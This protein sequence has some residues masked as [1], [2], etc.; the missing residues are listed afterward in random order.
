MKQSMRGTVLV[1]ASLLVLPLGCEKDEDTDTVAKGVRGEACLSHEDCGSHLVCGEDFTCADGDF[2]LEPTGKI[3]VGIQC[4]V[5]KDCCPEPSE[6]CDQYEDLCDDGDGDSTSCDMY[7]MYCE[8]DE[9]S[10]RC[11]TDLCVSLCEEDEDCTGGFCV[12]KRCAECKGDDDC[13]GDDLCV[14]NQCQPGCTDDLD[15]PVFYACQASQCVEVG[16]KTDRECIAH[17]RNVRAFCNP[18]KECRVPCDSDF[19]CED[20]YEFVDPKVCVKGLCEDVG[21][22]SASECRLRLGVQG[23]PDGFFMDAEC[24]DKPPEVEIKN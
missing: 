21:C 17:T 8:C 1:F 11:E 4:R 6:L 10:W 18:D 24:R 16:C 14:D 3:C 13:S 23:N 19:E 7:E 15:C 2:K 5:P 12:A 9:D 22:E 20:P